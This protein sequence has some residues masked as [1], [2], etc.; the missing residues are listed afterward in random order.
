MQQM[1]ELRTFNDPALKTM[2]NPV[3][4]N[5]DVSELIA[6]MRETL[7]HSENGV[8]LAAPQIGVTKR[9]I[10]VKNAAMINPQITFR[11]GM[12]KVGVEG[13]LSYPKDGDW[14][15]EADVERHVAVK[16]KFTDEYGKKK[17]HMMH[18][19]ESIITQHEI[20]HLDGICRVGDEWRG[21]R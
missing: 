9:V 4:Q 17:E 7:S 11:S 21:N 3:A 2:C 16:V 14:D 15:G 1:A 10:L 6:E 20:D 12:V 13:C 18:G 8:G 19:F 5:E